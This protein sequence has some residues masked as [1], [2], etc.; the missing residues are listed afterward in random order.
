MNKYNNGDIIFSLFSIVGLLFYIIPIIFII[1]FAI[2]TIKQLKR[3]TKLLEE[4]KDSI[5]YI[6]GHPTRSK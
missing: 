1:W 3:Q 4:M 2:S 5:N 6:N